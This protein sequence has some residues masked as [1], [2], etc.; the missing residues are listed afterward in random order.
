MQR[1]I[2][3]PAARHK[4]DTRYVASMIPCRVAVYQTSAGT[5]MISRMNTGVFAS[6]MESSLADVIQKSGAEMEAIIAKTVTKSK[7]ARN[8]TEL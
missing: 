3:R 8:A 4:D 1:E 6:M 5:V 2:Q 7:W